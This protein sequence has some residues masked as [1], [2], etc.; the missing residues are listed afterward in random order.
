MRIL[1]VI[2]KIRNT[3]DYPI[4]PKRVLP[5]ASVDKPAIPG[6]RQF[7]S[8]VVEMIGVAS[9]AADFKLR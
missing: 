8:M 2:G 6:Y 7:Q 3:I 4:T 5:A 9:P 1:A